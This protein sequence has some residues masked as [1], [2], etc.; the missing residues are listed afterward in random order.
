MLV[1][2]FVWLMTRSPS[3]A[4]I[5]GRPQIDIVSPST[6]A[7]AFG[8]VTIEAKVESEAQLSTV[9]C[10]VDG[11]SL[12]V[13][14][15]PPYRWRTD[16][17]QDN[18]ERII[19]VIAVTLVGGRTT[20]EIK[21]PRIEVDE[22]LDVELLQVYAVV[23]KDGL[24][25]TG[26]A[27][28]AFRIVDDVGGQQQVVTFEGGDLPISAALLVDSSASM[29]G[30]RLVAALDGVRSFA[31]GLN[32]EDEAMLV[33]FSDQILRLTPFTSEPEV[34]TQNTLGVEAVGSTSLNDHLYFALN[35]LDQRLGRRVVVLLSDGDDIT[36]V[37]P[38]EEV[39]WR[40]RRSQAVF[41]WIRLDESDE[42]EGHQTSK[43]RRFTSAWRDADANANELAKVRQAVADSGGREI[44][45]RKLDDL[46]A[47]FE[48][49]LAELRDQYV[50]GF[51]PSE[52]R[53]D[54][55]WRKF[56]IR[57]RGGGYKV[58]TRAGFVDE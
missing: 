42:A 29:G 57:V 36:S 34:L 38:M 11:V 49:V 19:E 12:G 44:V 16:V 47:S 51:Y 56:V 30:A 17:G 50:L 4:Q 14:E 37:L 53:N 45:V 54:G 15:A 18:E 24:R 20:A 2:G 5:G 13:L 40:A 35:R 41:Y 8:L 26:L 58:R 9:E 31:D 7:P 25:E 39:L 10:L 21:T 43:P 33:L 28:D 3:A 22:V 27:K 23:E 52:R 6:A 55:S 48:D 32:D 46:Q 1:F